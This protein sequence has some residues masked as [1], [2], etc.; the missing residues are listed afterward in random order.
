MRKIKATIVGLVVAAA[1][2]LPVAPAGALMCARD[3]DTVCRV[4]FTPLCTVRPTSC[5]R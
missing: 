2:L 4:V 3:L 5:P 1:L